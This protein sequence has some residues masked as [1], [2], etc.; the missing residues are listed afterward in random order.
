MILGD[1]PLYLTLTR[2]WESLGLWGKTKLLV[3][4]L[5]STFQKPN[6][7]EL[8]EWMKKILEGGD[9]DSEDLLT[10][11]IAELAK[12]FPSLEQV[13][14]KERDAYLACKLYQTCR[15]LLL[16]AAAAAAATNNR[17]PP[18][19]FKVVAIVGAG[20]VD[21]MCT[22]LTKSPSEETPEQVLA[23]LIQIK[24]TVPEEDQ[25]ILTQEVMEVNHELL[26]E[27]AREMQEM[28]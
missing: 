12:H 18:Q 20:H 13:I 14:I 19:H 3:G 24:N 17:R 16:Q 11:S 22:W 6:P 21:G 28:E 4:L 27:M 23:R 25:Q 8:R 7:E 15:Q 5:I 1:R 26:Q 2:A 10:Q 9:D